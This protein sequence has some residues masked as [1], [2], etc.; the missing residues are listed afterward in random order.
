MR[1]PIATI[2]EF[3]AHALAIEREAAERYEEFEAWFRDR[4]AD[5]L[6]GLCHNL[7]VLERSHLA[8]LIQASR[9]LTLPAIPA[10]GYR[11]LEAGPPEA[12]ARELFYRVASERHLMEIALHAEKKAQRFFEW[13]AQHAPA[14]PVRSLA[15]E[16]AQ[17][18]AEHVRWVSSA[19]DYAP[20]KPIDWAKVL[21]RASGPGPGVFL[22]AGDAL[23][24]PKPR[25]AP[26]H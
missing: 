24:R 15:R 5:V 16:L 20:A 9:G 12:L 19:I 2:E 4:D 6:A 25:K 14:E 8:A 18:E 23:P 1:C 11:W 22:G 13:V 17:E 21:A 10:G 3:Y 26:R 7:A